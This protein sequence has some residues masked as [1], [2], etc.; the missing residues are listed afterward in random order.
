[1]TMVTLP[2]IMSIAAIIMFL[3]SFH[4]PEGNKKLSSIILVD[5]WPL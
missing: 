5:L 3:S 2:K 1:M 4:V